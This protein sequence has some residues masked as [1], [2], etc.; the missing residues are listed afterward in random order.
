[1]QWRWWMVVIDIGGFWSKFKSFREPHP[2]CLLVTNPFCFG[3]FKVGKGQQ[4]VHVHVVVFYLLPDVG[5]IKW[6]NKACTKCLQIC[7]GILIQWKMLGFPSR[8][9]LKLNHWLFIQH[10]LIGDC[11]ICYVFC[12][13]VASVAWRFFFV[14]P[15]AG[16]DLYMKILNEKKTRKKLRCWMVWEMCFV[17]SNALVIY[18]HVPISTSRVAFQ[19]ASKSVCTPCFLV[20]FCS[21]SLDTYWWW[22]KI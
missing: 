20:L 9:Y 21:D 16:C 3:V 19:N 2:K 11:S 17:T 15:W 13:P 5:R 4:L 1:M 18:S 6:K 7:Q 22:T 8:Y 12:N 14:S 10:R